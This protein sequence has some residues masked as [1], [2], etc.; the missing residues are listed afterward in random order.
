MHATTHRTKRC[1]QTIECKTDDVDVGPTTGY[2]VLRADM[3][4]LADPKCAYAVG[5]TTTLPATI[6]IHVTRTGLH[7]GL[8]PLDCAVDPHVCAA[9]SASFPP[10]ELIFVEVQ[11]M[12]AV[13]RDG[14]CAATDALK[15]VRRIP[16]GEWRRMCTGT[17]VVCELD[18]STRIE[19]YRLGRL[20]SPRDPILGTRSLPAIEWAD[21][22][23]DW[24]VDGLRH[25]CD[26]STS[27]R[28]CGGDTC[29]RLPAVVCPDGTRHWYARGMFIETRASRPDRH[30]SLRHGVPAT[31]PPASCHSFSLTRWCAGF[32]AGI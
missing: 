17:V 24:Y 11:A 3:T 21:G 8:A 32:F 31:A 9:L 18:G 28:A 16:T 5:A 23:R 26:C 10:P 1:R 4:A 29:A 25:R 2:K 14:G 27:D 7:Y 22:R 6:P 19:R 12:G 15:I 13:V 30:A 20:H